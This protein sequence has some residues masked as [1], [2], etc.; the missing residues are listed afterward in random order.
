MGRTDKADA[1]KQLMRAYRQ[2]RGQALRSIALGDSPNDLGMLR[3]ADIAVVVPGRSEASRGMSEALC[4]HPCLI[5]APLPGPA[6]WHAAMQAILTNLDT[7][8][9][10]VG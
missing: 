5:E 10:N 7:E 9:Q 6:G 1:M 2:S 8:H 3:A 4:D